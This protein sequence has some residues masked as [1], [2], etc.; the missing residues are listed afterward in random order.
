M[1]AT[2]GW[3]RTSTQISAH[4][5]SREVAA[6]RRFQQTMSKKSSICTLYMVEKNIF[7]TFDV[8]NLDIDHEDAQKIGKCT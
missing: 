1:Y 2:S 7:T 6:I 8:I 3:N 4:I 5:Q